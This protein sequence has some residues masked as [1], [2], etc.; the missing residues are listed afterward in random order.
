VRLLLIAG[1]PVVQQPIDISWPPGPQQQTRS[2]LEA[3]GWDR[4][5][6]RGTPDRCMDPDSANNDKT[7]LYSA[8]LKQNNTAVTRT[9]YFVRG[10]FI[11]AVRTSERKENIINVGVAYVNFP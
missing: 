3:A 7:D 10:Y 1:P 9:I 5:T 4:Q 11:S 6:D 2:R 8:H